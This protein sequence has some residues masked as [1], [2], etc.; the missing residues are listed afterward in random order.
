[1][2]S[3]MLRLNQ[4]IFVIIFLLVGIVSH[5]SATSFFLR[6]SSTGDRDFFVGVDERF[7]VE[8]VI[9]PQGQ[10]VTAFEIYLSFSNEYLELIDA[11][12]ISPGLQPVKQGKDLPNGWQNFDNDTHGDPGNKLSN[13]QID[14]SRGLIFGADLSIKKKSVIGEITFIAK[15]PTDA[16][17]INVDNMKGANRLTVVRIGNSPTTP[18]TE[19]FSSNVSISQGLLEF[20]DSFPKNVTFPSNQVYNELQLSDYVVSH[21]SV[22]SQPKWSVSK[23]PN[24]SVEIAPASLIV[25]LSSVDDW[26]GTETLKFTVTDPQENSSSKP[27]EVKITAPPIF[28]L[29]EKPFI[30]DVNKIR[31]INLTEYLKDADDPKL[32][33]VDLVMK[34]NPYG[35]DI[36]KLNGKQLTVLY[37]KPAMESIIVVAS[38]ADGNETSADIPIGFAAPDSGPIISIITFPPEITV[39]FDGPDADVPALELDDMVFDSD[40]ADKQL[41][42]R[43]EGNKNIEV[44]INSATRQAKIIRNSG[45]QGV[46]EITFIAT[47]PVDLFDQKMM[48]ITFRT[49]TGAPIIGEIPPVTIPFQKEQSLDLRGFVSDFES[50]SDQMSWDINPGKFVKTEISNKGLAVFSGSEVGSEE[51]EVRVIDPDGKEAKGK[52]SVTVIAPT[53][54]QISNKF[55]SRITI[56]RGEPTVVFDLD[57]FLTGGI[58]SSDVTWKIDGYDLDKLFVSIDDDRNVT[59]RSLDAWD[60]G[61]QTVTFTAENQVKIPVSVKTRVFTKFPP[62]IAPIGDLKISGG[63]SLE[64]E[65]NKSIKD[66]DTKPD[67]I[68]WIATDFLPLAVNIDPETKIATVSASQELSGNEYKFIFIATDPDELTD[69]VTVNVQVIKSF[70]K[71]PVVNFLPNVKFKQG[72]EDRSITLHKY[73]E[74]LDTPKKD[75]KWDYAPKESKIKVSINETTTNV[76]FSSGL[77]FIGSQKFIFTVTDPDELS[78]SLEMTAVVI[79]RSKE[80]GPPEVKGIPDIKIRKGTTESIH[81]NDYVTDPDTLKVDIKWSHVPKD[82][83]IEVE[84]DSKTSNVV[85]SPVVGFLGEDQIIFT[86][87]DPEN[88]SSSQEVKIS[89]LEEIE[90]NSGVEGDGGDKNGEGKPPVIVDFPPVEIKQGDVDQSVIL[91]DYVEDPDTPKK[92]LKWDYEPKDGNVDV[93]I[94]DKTSKVILSPKPDFVGDQK[95][96]FTVIDPTN[97]SSKKV[98]NVKVVEQST[99][100]GPPTLKG[101]PDIEMEQ[102]DVD[103]KIQLANYVKDPDTPKK[104]LKWDYEPKDGNVDVKIDEVTLEAILIPKSGFEGTQEIEF[105]VT[106]PDKLSG[107][108]KLKVTVRK[109]SDEKKSDEDEK[110]SLIITEIPNVKFEQGTDDKSIIL[111]KYVENSKVP[112]EELVWDYEPKDGNIEVEIDKASLQVTLRA[113]PEFFG[114]QDLEFKVSEPEGKTASKKIAVTVEKRE[115]TRSPLLIKLPMVKMDEGTTY[116]I[117]NLDE[118]VADADTPK[119]DLTWESKGSKNLTVNIDQETRVM[120]IIPKEEFTGTESI[121]IIVTDPEQNQAKGVIIVDVR[122]TEPEVKS[123]SPVISFPETKIE[124]GKGVK[125]KLDKYVKDQDTPNEELIWSIKENNTFDTTIEERTLKIKLSEAKKSFRGSQILV[126]TVVDPENNKGVGVISIKVVDAPDRT[127]PGF[128]FFM[129]PNPIQPDFLTIVVVANEKLKESPKFQINGVDVS[130]SEVGDNQ[131]KGL[132]LLSNGGELKIVIEGEDVSGNK[133]TRNKT[134]R[135]NTTLSSP[136]IP[137]PNRD[138]LHPN[139]PNPFNPETWIPFQL[140]QDAVVKL[141]IFSSGGELV[142]TLNFG[143]LPAGLYIDR[144]QAAFWN[145]RNGNNEYVASGVYFGV[146][147]IGNNKKYVQRLL[148]AK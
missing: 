54:P 140:A 76:A 70:K 35:D 46:E 98:L 141:D 122:S 52:V 123:A 57:E 88:Q 95:V 131:W 62:I 14:Y 107:T 53:P 22:E 124:A 93:K 132:H 83:N 27:L 10:Q 32:D 118:F 48:K 9:D 92:D 147:S 64:V 116:E 133:G 31:F 25:S 4:H 75:L 41:N 68:S 148:M 51:I 20:L 89:V 143:Q 71:P 36:V 146:L 50:N 144:S 100:K 65:L 105:I 106:D 33:N 7:Q 90:V 19:S 108:Q 67:K 63:G 6:H 126:L 37:D 103:Q 142:R 15:E 44:D 79:E 59:M 138:A 111:N 5:I 115:E 16:T 139:Y 81:L 99:E 91:I 86:A 84:I 2:D 13:F 72:D 24:V 117:S 85:L 61:I 102:G 42:W 39:Y 127:P 17:K 82:G 74:D 58:D 49:S 1:M 55:P 134:V 94:D 18:F 40:Y 66:L 77:E 130:I 60:T 110:K 119:E 11:D 56:P 101:M 28:E 29:P 121:D 97:L 113:K 120:E 137:F 12:P 47:N 109:K 38:D 129:I 80:K 43:T 87:S 104:D 69:N 30:T 78:D 73:V 145:G 3:K 136:R 8:M 26:F 23:S 21:H 45:W 128:R 125:L 135:L 34:E 96:T 114:T 112:Q